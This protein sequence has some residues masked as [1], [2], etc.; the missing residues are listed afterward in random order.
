M[1]FD[2]SPHDPSQ[3]HYACVERIDA[4]RHLR[5]RDI[6]RRSWIAVQ[7]V[8]ADIGYYAND[9]A[10]LIGKFRTNALAD[11][12]TVRQRVA[13]GPEL[14]GHCLIDDNHGR[15]SPAV[16]VSE[17]ASAQQRDLE[18]IEITR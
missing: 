4:V 15:R 17:C 10:R 1:G 9:L 2:A 11:D 3:R 18:Y 7:A 16:L 5:L 6:H 12:D 14:L 8:V 13:V